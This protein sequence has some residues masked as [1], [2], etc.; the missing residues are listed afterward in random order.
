MILKAVIM[1]LALVAGR[2]AIP[3]MND[4]NSNFAFSADAVATVVWD[5]L[6]QLNNNASG[7]VE[8]IAELTQKL[9]NIFKENMWLRFHD[10]LFPD[11]M[12]KMLVTFALDLYKCLTK[13]L[14]RKKEEIQKELEDLQVEIEPH[15]QE[16][17]QKIRDNARLLEEHL[18]PYS[19]VLKRHV[20]RMS[21][22]NAQVMKCIKDLE[23]G[24]S[25]NAEHLQALVPS[26]P[27]KIKE[28][29]TV[30]LLKF[31]ANLMVFK[32]EVKKT[33]DQFMKEL[34]HSL[35]PFLKD[36]HKL[37]HQLEGLS[38]Q[39]NKEM[40][41]LV[42]NFSARIYELWKLLDPLPDA[43]PKVN[44]EE[45]QKFLSK[46][47]GIVEEQVKIFQCKVS[48]YIETFNKAMEQKVEE[49][50][51]KLETHA[52]YMEDHLIFLEKDL[53]DKVKSSFK[54]LKEVQNRNIENL[55]NPQ[56]AGTEP[57]PLVQNS[58]GLA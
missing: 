21:F 49:F 8:Q 41:K 2:S 17:R 56:G 51:Q 29:I 57:C 47:N 6:S 44:K 37:D 36:M 40:L 33:I 53:K 11:E 38:F 54:I 14:Q 12:E 55:P 50:G 45:L 19:S 18:E 24:P 1:S 46:L 13:D 34:S 4:D 7:T 30:N 39:L 28:N 20:D 25:D 31:Q 42:A 15:F 5:Y 10:K 48:S 43:M 16:V 32:Q 23:N 22:L 58:T 26:M 52:G 9:K 27:N 3:E 35:A